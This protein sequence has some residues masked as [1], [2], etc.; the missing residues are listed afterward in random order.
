MFNMYLIRD[1]TMQG[2]EADEDG[3]EVGYGGCTAPRELL[4]K[5][6]EQESCKN[7]MPK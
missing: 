2:E 5:F 6:L 3:G 1:L 7:T 4:R